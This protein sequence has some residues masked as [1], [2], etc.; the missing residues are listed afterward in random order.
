MPTKRSRVHPNYRTKY[1]VSSWSSYDAALVQRGNLNI[2]MSPEAIENWNAKPQMSLKQHGKA[3]QAVRHLPN[4][5]LSCYKS[6][7]RIHKKTLI[8]ESL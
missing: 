6:I 5:P 7:R 4:R 1:R 2:W 8:L 3:S